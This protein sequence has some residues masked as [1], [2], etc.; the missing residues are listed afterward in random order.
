MRKTIIRFAMHFYKFQNRCRYCTKELG[1]SKRGEKDVGVKKWTW[2]CGNCYDNRFIN[3]IE[4]NPL[5]LAKF[6]SIH[7][8]SPREEITS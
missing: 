2:W 5:L 7:G 4:S 8:K 3:S 1:D 6:H